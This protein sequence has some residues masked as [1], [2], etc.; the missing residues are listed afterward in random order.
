LDE[1]KKLKWAQFRF[2]VIAPLVC[3][4]LES[5]DR[6]QLRR[7]ILSKRHL[8][9]DGDERLISERT[10]RSWIAR[11]KNHDFDGLKRMTPPTKGRYHAIPKDIIDK[12]VEL[13]QELPTR[14]IK[15]ILS[16]LKTQNVDI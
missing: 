4:R 6:S 3:R 1:E 2:E 14:S 16:L 13:R 11:Y 12:A 7:Q 5:E 15:R 8:T 9:P 10:L